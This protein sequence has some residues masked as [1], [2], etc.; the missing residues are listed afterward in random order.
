MDAV[1]AFAARFH[2]VEALLR[3]SPLPTWAELGPRLGLSDD[4]WQSH[5]P[6]VEVPALTAA[7][8]R[9]AIDWTDACALWLGIET[10]GAVGFLESA[11]LPSW[12]RLASRDAAYGRRSRSSRRR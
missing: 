9:S 2:R 8:K 4:R 12:M 6:V 10:D 1:D 5:D 7:L 11:G 3:Q